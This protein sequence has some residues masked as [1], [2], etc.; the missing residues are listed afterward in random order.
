VIVWLSPDPALDPP[1]RIVARARTTV[2]GYPH[3]V[4]PFPWAWLMRR[5]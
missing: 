4:I 1:G 2:E 3:F 5:I